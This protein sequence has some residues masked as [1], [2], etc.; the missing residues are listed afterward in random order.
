MAEESVSLQKHLEARLEDA[1]KRYQQRFDAQTKAI[2]AALMAAEKA[3][4]KAET[5]NDK[6]FEGV[7]E[8]RGS[9]ND[10]VSTLM[11]RNEAVP[12]FDALVEKIDALQRRMDTA[13]GRQAVSDPA[14]V[15]M[16]AEVKKLTASQ[17]QGSGFKA[18]QVAVVGGIIAFFSLIGSVVYI[19]AELK[20][21]PAPQVTYTAPVAA[22][23]A[24]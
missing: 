8:M 15:E 4:T 16:I 12:R 13:T 19:V 6:R 24:K 5:A 1:D 11:P 9:L 18:G 2:D 20:P 17:Q 3:V 22:P 23:A 10:M 21:A 14:T 7:N